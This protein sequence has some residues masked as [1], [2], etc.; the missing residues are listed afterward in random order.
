[1][2]HKI[3]NIKDAK[4]G[5][6]LKIGDTLRQ[7]PELRMTSERAVELVVKYER[8]F[9]TVRSNLLATMEQDLKIRVNVDFT[10]ICR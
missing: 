9:T 4:K 3:Y 6:L 2:T 1:M 5:V 8:A 7:Y 10:Y